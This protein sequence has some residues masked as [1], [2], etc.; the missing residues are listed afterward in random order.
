MMQGKGWTITKSYIGG[1]C[2]EAPTKKQV[3]PFTLYDDD[4][5]LYFYGLMTEKL[6]DSHRIFD[7]LDANMD[8]YGCTTMKV[9]TKNGWETI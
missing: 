3:I 6:Y 8:D 9:K 7:P 4:G 1:I 2:R 5:N